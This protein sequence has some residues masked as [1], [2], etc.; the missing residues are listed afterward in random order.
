MKV[1]D[2]QIHRYLD[3]V[4]PRKGMCVK[5]QI[6]HVESYYAEAIRTQ[7]PA[8]IALSRAALKELQEQQEEIQRE[9]EKQFSDEYE[10]G[11]DDFS[12]LGLDSRYSGG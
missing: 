3:H 1:T 9:V 12:V 5:L 10:F 2:E 4:L 6:D 7:H 8:K 11:P